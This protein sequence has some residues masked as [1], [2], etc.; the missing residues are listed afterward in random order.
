M[1]ELPVLNIFG[2]ILIY[3]AKF[4]IVIASILAVYKKKT[5]GSI[6]LLIGAISILVGDVASTVLLFHAGR[7]GAEQVVK[8]TGVNS[9]VAACTHLLFATGVLAYIV[10]T[11]KD[12]TKTE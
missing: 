1:E 11:A 6:L 5:T 12:K 3:I 9:L 4:L 8:I 10:Q 2:G 7:T